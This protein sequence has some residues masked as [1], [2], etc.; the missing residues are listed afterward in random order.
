MGGVASAVPASS[1]SRL[2]E[3]EWALDSGAGENLS[4]KKAFMKQG[5]PDDVFQEFETCSNFP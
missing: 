1:A 3:L 4:S 5:V 2:F